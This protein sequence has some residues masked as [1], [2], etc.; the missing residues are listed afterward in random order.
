MAEQYA[1]KLNGYYFKD[2]AGRELIANETSARQSQFTNLQGQINNLIENGYVPYAVDSTSEMTNH[3]RI[4]VLKST[5]KWYYYNSDAS[6]WTIG[7]D[8]QSVDTDS[9]LTAIRVAEGCKTYALSDFTWVA[10]GVNPSTHKMTSGDADRIRT[11]GIIKVKAGSVINFTGVAS[12]YQFKVT[13]YEQIPLFFTTFISEPVSFSSNASTVTIDRDCYIII[14]IKA[15]DGSAISEDDFDTIAGYISTSSLY[16]KEDEYPTG[17]ITDICTTYTNHKMDSNGV[18]T[19]DSDWNLTAPIAVKEG[20]YVGIVNTSSTADTIGFL[21]IQDN[22]YVKYLGFGYSTSQYANGYIVPTGMRYVVFTYKKALADNIFIHIQSRPDS[23]QSQLRLI[24]DT[25]ET[26]LVAHRGLEYFAP[27][28]T[29]P[30]YTIAGEAGMWGCKLDICETADGKFV[31]SHDNTVDRMF[32]GSGAI[33]DMTLAQLQELTVDAGNHIADYPNEKIVTFEE[34]LEICKKYGMHPVI[35]MKNLAS[36]T[37][38]ANIVA[39]LDSYGLTENTVCQC[40]DTRRYYT[41]ELR[42]LRKDIPIVYWQNTPQLATIAHHPLPIFNSVQALSSWN[43]DYTNPTY[44]ELIKQFNM[45]LCVAVI[46]GNNAQTKI[47]T[48]IENGC[49]YAVT[50]RITPADIAPDTYPL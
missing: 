39:I 42:N 40:S 41:T 15:T 33:A 21:F 37:S 26:K 46:D 27:E 32:N 28:A 45:P 30:A 8:Y 47:E 31:M 35:E 4:Y 3:R 1:Q 29:V 6:T 44:L 17:D 43:T 38:V 50:D 24:C 18:I 14:T 16:I 36:V 5:G 49:V 13:E 19:S 9:T 22:G 25:P 11:S 12:G 34:A 20:D 7:G 10:G 2:K 23:Y 48:A